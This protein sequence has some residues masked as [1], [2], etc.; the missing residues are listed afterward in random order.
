MFPCWLTDFAWWAVAGVCSVVMAV[1]FAFT[2]I[3]FAPL[4][5]HAESLWTIHLRDLAFVCSHLGFALLAA[6]LRRFQPRKG[7]PPIVL[8]QPFAY[9]LWILDFAIIIVGYSNA[10]ATDH[11]VAAMAVIGAVLKAFQA[12]VGWRL[13]WPEAE[14][15]FIG[16]MIKTFSQRQVTRGRPKACLLKIYYRT[17]THR[18]TH[19]DHHHLILT[20]NHN[21]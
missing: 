10:E 5:V 11:D 3:R 14:A 6:L 12:R 2:L 13:F 7:F 1:P 16:F 19:P 20:P 17:E 18:A 21:F 15:S 8:L 4:L 9:Y